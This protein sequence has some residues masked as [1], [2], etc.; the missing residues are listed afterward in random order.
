MS[1]SATIRRLDHPTDAERDTL[2]DLLVATVADGASVGF[3]P[4][5]SI[6]EARAYWSDIPD[7][8]T[9]L[10]VLEQDGRIVGTVQAQLASRANGHHRAEIAR[11]LVHPE[12]RRQ[13][14]ARRLMD[15]IEAEL[16]AAGRWLVV[17][18][19]R[20]GDPSN[21]LYQSLGY[22]QAGRIP[23]FARSA[24]GGYDAT[25]IYFRRLSGPGDQQ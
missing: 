19:T 15:A 25:C 7:A 22:E 17:L 24:D 10:L 20:E 5:L 2:A 12:A 13:G 1:S 18:D 21:G 3:L 9:I 6:A 8:Q 16:L 14:H 4:P 23:D 11:L